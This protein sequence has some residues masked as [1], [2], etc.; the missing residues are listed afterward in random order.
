MRSQLIVVSEWGKAFPHVQPKNTFVPGN[1][2]SR[3]GFEVPID[4]L[5]GSI[6]GLGEEQVGDWD[7]TEAQ[8]GPD[9]EET[10]FEVREAV[11]S[12]LHD[13]V[14]LAEKLKGQLNFAFSQTP[15]LTHN[16]DDTYDDP[17]YGCGK[18]GSFRAH[19]ESVDFGGV[20]PGR[21]VSHLYV[22]GGNLVVFD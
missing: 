13:H 7:E 8:T 2:D 21:G 15:A 18:S 9:D 3:L 4:V 14:V 16:Q 6:P 19:L 20:K 1:N 17:L 22:N 5:Q 10:P 11:G 12:D